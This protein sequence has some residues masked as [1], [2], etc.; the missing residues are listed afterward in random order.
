MNCVLS[1]FLLAA[2][3][4]TAVETFQAQVVARFGGECEGK[5]F[6]PSPK[7]A[8]LVQR[9]KQR[10]RNPC[11]WAFCEGAHVY[12][13]NADGRQEYFVPLAC[14]ATGNC[15]WG[16]FS[17]RPARLR[18]TFTGWFFYIYRRTGSW[19]P[20]SAYIREGASDGIIVRLRNRRGTYVQR[21]ET[22][23][24][25]YYGND[26]PFLKRMGIPKCG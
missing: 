15:K 17:D 3:L 7:L 25:G 24:Q 11:D 18:G 5:R 6:Q 12:D 20:I 26:H 10:E 19:N 22:T 1:V 8:S 9:V 4:L 21:S 23:D 16:I 14:G 2:C 13:L